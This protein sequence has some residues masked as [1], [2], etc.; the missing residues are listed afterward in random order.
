MR[1]KNLVNAKYFL[2]TNYPDRSKRLQTFFKEMNIKGVTVAKKM[3][4][5]ATYI[6]QLLHGHS[7]VTASVAVRMK[8]LY[9]KLNLSW[10]LDGEG[11]ML[12][13]QTTELIIT[14]ESSAAY[15]NQEE[16]PLSGLELLLED[17][18]RRIDALEKEVTLLRKE[19]S[20][21]NGETK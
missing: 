8:K 7:T 4:V 5:K 6:S 18:G 13:E 21:L 16:K 15:G 2:M 9:P 19:V 1:K 10:L 12:A 20:R 17:Y 14:N 3:D 11:E